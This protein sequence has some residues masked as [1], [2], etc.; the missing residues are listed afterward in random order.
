MMQR[1]VVYTVGV[2]ALGTLLFIWWCTMNKKTELTSCEQSVQDYLATTNKDVSDKIVAKK[3]DNVAVKYVGRFEDGNV[4]D[5]NVESV[6]KACGK[7]QTGRNY[8]DTLDFQIGAGQMIKG[9]DAA[10]EWMKQGETV[11]VTLKPEDAYGK[12]DEKL[13]VKVK[14]SDMQNADQYKKGQMLQD[15]YGR[16]FK[17]VDVDDENITIDANSEMAGKTLIFDITLEKV[18]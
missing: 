7:Y 8:D 15:P 2:L 16:T 4:F 3:G 5:T 12:R 18:K 1:K 13:I 10:V 17:I 11:T 9:F 14:K 6:A